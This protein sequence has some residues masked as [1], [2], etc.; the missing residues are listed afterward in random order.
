M[1]TGET[2]EINWTKTL[3]ILSAM[4]TPIENELALTSIR[5]KKCDKTEMYRHNLIALKQH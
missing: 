1:L 5:I 3:F 2:L 4:T